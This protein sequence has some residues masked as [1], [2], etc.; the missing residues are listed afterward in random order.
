MYISGLFTISDK[1]P[2][3]LR[4]VGGLLGM[5]GSCL[6]LIFFPNQVVFFEGGLFLCGGSALHGVAK[7]LKDMDV[8][9]RTPQANEGIRGTISRLLLLVAALAYGAGI[10]TW[11]VTVLHLAGFLS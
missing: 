7:Y 2:G 6:F 5:I 3:T 10:L 9:S 8:R 11:F 4:I 1:R